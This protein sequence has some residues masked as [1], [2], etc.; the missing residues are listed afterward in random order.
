MVKNLPAIQEN[1]VQSLGWNIPWKREWPHTAVFLPGVFHGLRSLEYG[2]AKS[3][4][5]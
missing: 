5:N 3:G 1:W 2:L 4:H